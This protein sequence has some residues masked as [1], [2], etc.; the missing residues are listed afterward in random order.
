LTPTELTPTKKA[1][2]DHNTTKE[3]PSI[4][5]NMGECPIVAKSVLEQLVIEKIY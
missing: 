5:R 1:D 3:K 4:S 2:I